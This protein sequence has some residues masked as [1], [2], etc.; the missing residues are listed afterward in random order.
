ME[1]IQAE[2]ALTGFCIPLVPQLLNFKPFGKGWGG[3]LRC[4]LSGLGLG[5]Y[6]ATVTLLFLV[7][8]LV[9]SV[10]FVSLGLGKFRFDP[11]CLLFHALF[12]SISKFI[13][14]DSQLPILCR[15]SLI[16]STCS[17]FLSVLLLTGL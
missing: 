10:S 12:F 6:A 11:A 3:A 15:S 4:A 8:C 16:R 1:K 13:H 7:S 14:F 9:F 17:H 2:L 5:M